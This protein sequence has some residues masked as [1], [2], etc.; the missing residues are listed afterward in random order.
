[1]PRG[2]YGHPRVWAISYERGTPVVDLCRLPS[3]GQLTDQRLQGYLAHKNAQ[4]APE[5][6][7]QEAG[8]SD[9]PPL[10]HQLGLHLVPSVRKSFESHSPPAKRLAA[11]SRLFAVFAGRCDRAGRCTT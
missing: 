3:A 4:R 10:S 2:T 5:R 11:A 7:G 8:L 6:D 9:R 1:M